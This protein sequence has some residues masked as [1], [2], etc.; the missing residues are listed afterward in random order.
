MRSRSGRARAHRARQPAVAREPVVRAAKLVRE[1]HRPAT[2][3]VDGHAVARVDD[4]PGPVE[5][6]PGLELVPRGVPREHVGG[7]FELDVDRVLGS[8]LSGSGTA[9][10]H[11]MREASCTSTRRSTSVSSP[12]SSRG[13]DAAPVSLSPGAEGARTARVPLSAVVDIDSSR[14]RN[15]RTLSRNRETCKPFVRLRSATD[16]LGDGRVSA[17]VAGWGQGERPRSP[18]SRRGRRSAAVEPRAERGRNEAHGPRAPLTK[19]R[20]R[21]SS[22]AFHVAG[23]LRKPT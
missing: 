14:V 8:R 10:V 2:K 21:C 11:S 15:T 6:R 1:R 9:T 5:A 16:G 18:P 22:S 4:A 19:I 3:G 17:P 23:W 20:L 13:V 7:D 12:V